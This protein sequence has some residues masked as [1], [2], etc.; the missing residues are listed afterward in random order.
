MAEGLWSQS[1]AV[2]LDVTQPWGSANASIIGSHYFH[3][4][5]KNRLSFYG[6]FS[7]RIW[8][9]FSLNADGG[10]ALIHDQLSLVKG[11]LTTDEILL[12]LK[13]LSTTYEYYVSLGVSYSFGSKMSRAVNPRMSGAGSFYY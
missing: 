1:L 5:S 7:V 3:D 9:G 13:Q 8:K 11:E 2:S 12:R 4:W 6:Y 10:F